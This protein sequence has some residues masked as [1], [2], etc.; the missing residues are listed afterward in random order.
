MTPS[1]PSVQFSDPARSSERLLDGRW[2]RASCSAGGQPTEADW[3]P[4]ASGTASGDDCEHW[5]RQ[6]VEIDATQLDATQ[7]GRQLLLCFDGIATI[8]DVLWNGKVIASSSNM[9]VPLSVDVSGVAIVGPN[10][11]EVRCRSLDAHL[12]ELKVPRSR[13]KTRLVEDQKL[14]GVRTTL[15]GRIPSWTPPITIVGVWKSARL[16][17]LEPQVVTAI[18]VRRDLD[19]AG[20]LRSLSVSVEFAAGQ[21]LAEWSGQVSVGGVSARLSKLE[22]TVKDPYSLVATIP[23]NSL[24]RW[25]PHTHGTPK[26]HQALISV[27]STDGQRAEIDLGQIGIRDIAINHGADDQGFAVHVNGLSVFCRGGSLMPL[28]SQIETRDVLNTLCRA[29]INMVRVSGT[30]MPMSRKTLE[31]CD[32]LGILVWHDLPFANF[33][34]PANEEFLTEIIAETKSLVDQWTLSASL[35]IVCGGSEVEQQAA[36]MGIG[37]QSIATNPVLD[38][39]AATVAASRPDVTFV[40]SSPT[41]GHLPFSVD[42]GIAHYFGVGAYLRPMEDARLSGL[43]FAAECLAFSNVPSQFLVDSLISEPYAASGG[44]SGL[45]LLKARVPRDRGATWDFQDVREWYSRLLFGISTEGLQQSDP[46]WYYTLARA[47]STELFARTFA[48]WRTSKSTCDG[49]LV[50][51][52]N[53]LWAAA[54]WGVIDASGDPKSALHGMARSLSARAIVPIDEGLNGLDWW[55]FNDSPKMLSGRLYL[56]SWRGGRVLVSSGEIGVNVGPHSSLQVRS[57]AVFGVFTDPTYAYKFGEPGHDVI[58]ARL[59]CDSDGQVIESEYVANLASLERR[60]DLGLT[61]T[62]R[63]TEPDTLEVSLTAD[64]FARLVD[65]EIPGA[66]I[67]PNMVNVLPGRPCRVR[68]EFRPEFRPEFRLTSDT[69]PLG[70]LRALN[71]VGPITFPPPAVRGPT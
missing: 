60:T 9:F 4:T 53:D 23:T 1:D 7:L 69:P 67:W 57:D 45:E 29:G 26:R 49:A 40:R 36:M 3:R 63:W 30:M 14:R 34:Y 70:T 48:E 62:T 33:D 5:F 22:N 61:A 43:R 66:Q 11:L 39:L 13:W 8:A 68:A 15:L 16:L 41:G 32:E 27:A 10:T 59:V 38:A 65:I 2:L 64:R 42:T 19:S 54:G 47:T 58:S 18:A 56:D 24:E 12:S 55:V 46:D 20:A 37:A 21:A 52:L 35:A 28:D 6:D 50:W 25:Y 31:L 71:G 17:I 51:F 44:G